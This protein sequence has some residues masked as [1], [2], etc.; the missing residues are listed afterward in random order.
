MIVAGKCPPEKKELDKITERGF[1]HA[2]LYLEKEHLDGFETA[3]K[4]CQEANV[5]ISSVHTPHVKP[6]NKEYFQL[7]D[8]LARE[9]NA[10]LV[11]HSQYLH[12]VHIDRV[13]EKYGFKSD[14]G[15]ENNPGMSIPHLEKMI[16][17]PGHQMVLDTAHLYMSSQKNFQDNLDYFLNNHS[18]QINVVHVCNSTMK[19]DGLPFGEGDMN[20]ERTIKKVKEKFDGT[21]TLE[22]MPQYQKKALQKWNSIS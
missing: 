8:K 15:Y 7:S 22:V 14:Y 10:K 12:H 18:D 2:E 4:R 3:L 19:K 21:V 5:N 17:K 1:E 11:V 16:L 13:L 9:L 6:G 20:M